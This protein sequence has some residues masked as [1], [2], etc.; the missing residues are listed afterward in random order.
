MHV[1]IEPP[2]LEL[3]AAWMKAEDLS[4]RSI[5]ERLIFMRMVARET[6]PLRAVTRQELI[7]WMAGK[8]WANKT[9]QHYR[10]TLHTFFTWLQ[11][12]GFRPDNPAARLPRVKMKRTQPNP[13]SVAEIQQLLESGI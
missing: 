2:E 5:R 4:P 12:E 8:S 11:D 6:G 13:F 10:S 3:W 9:R 7:R 1:G